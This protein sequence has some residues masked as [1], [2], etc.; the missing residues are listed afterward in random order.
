VE[1][2][3]ACFFL[4]A[5]LCFGQQFEIGAIGGYGIYRDVRVNGAGAE[6]TAGIRNRFAVGALVCEDLYEHFSGEVRYL[7][8][9]GDPFLALGGR[10][11]NIQGQSHTFSYDVLFHVR[12]RDQKLRPYF[13]VGA[14]AKYYRATGAEPNPQP[15]HQVA[16]LVRQNQWRFL[17]DFGAGVK[18]RVHR[19]VVLRLDFRDYITPF[20][21][22]LYVPTGS[23]TDRGL[24][25]MFTPTAGIGFAF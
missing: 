11:G 6:A 23:G 13:A 17:A 9:D 8:Q 21:K 10:S 25:Q 4:C 2:K 14:G 1:R 20:P 15:A 18:Y 16:D 7:Y 5:G 24:F 12:D 22:K 19:H 3:S